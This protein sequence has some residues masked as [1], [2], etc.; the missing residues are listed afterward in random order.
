MEQQTYKSSKV[1]VPHTKIEDY[2]LNPTKPHFKEFIDVGYMRGEGEKI[3]KDLE[4]GFDINNATNF[5]CYPDGAKE[6]VIYML[7]GITKKRTFRTVWRIDKLSTLPRFIT[8]FRDKEGE[9]Y[10]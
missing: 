6:F 3:F 4:S 9:Q 10:V 7:L 1:H 5:I 2:L 8:A